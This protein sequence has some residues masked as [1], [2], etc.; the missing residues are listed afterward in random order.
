MKR[1]T[2]KGYLRPQA[3]MGRKSTVSNAFASAL[4]PHDPYVP[5]E[6]VEALRD[7]G[8]DPD[9][10]LECVYC[11]APASSWDHVFNRV[12]KGDY[13]GHGNHIRNLVPCCLPCNTRKG[14]KSWKDWLEL[15][16]PPDM[17]NR[18]SRMERFLSR[19][20]PATLTQEQMHAFAAPELKRFL[21]IRTEVFEL[22]KEAD[23]LAATIRQRC[24]QRDDVR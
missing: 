9:G 16:A 2:I 11:G 7:L 20:G 17:Q 23:A 1:A 15:L 21:Q 6:V 14:Q 19:P 4:A 3:I 5:E 24:S 18:V 8:Q 22:M 13:S 10:E 12:T